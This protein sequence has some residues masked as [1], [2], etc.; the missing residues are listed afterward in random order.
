[1][2]AR[3]SSTVDIRKRP[4]G[5][6]NAPQLPLDSSTF[7]FQL[8]DNPRKVCRVCCLLAEDVTKTERNL[9][10]NEHS[11][12]KL[13]QVLNTWLWAFSLGVHPSGKNLLFLPE[14]L[15]GTEHLPCDILFRSCPRLLEERIRELCAKAVAAQDSDQLNPI[16]SELRVALH[17]Q[18][19]LAKVL[20]AERTRMLNP[21]VDR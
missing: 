11:S 5:R 8:S 21:N 10:D 3:L 18:D 7:L 13:V 14:T 12:V 2:A 17:E 9:S 20:I 6:V 19:M 15:H 4:E 1:L 16:L